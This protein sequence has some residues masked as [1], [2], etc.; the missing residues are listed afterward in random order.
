MMTKRSNHMPTLITSDSTNS[1]AVEVRS[2]LNQSS[3]GEMTL[4]VTMIQ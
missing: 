1:A 2:R 3:C 4:Q